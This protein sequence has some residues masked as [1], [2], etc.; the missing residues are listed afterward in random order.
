ME[1][2]I[3]GLIIA[4][5]QQLRAIFRTEIDLLTARLWVFSWQRAKIALIP[6]MVRERMVLKV[7]EVT[8]YPQLNDATRT[9]PSPPG[10]HFGRSP[11]FLNRWFCRSTSPPRRRNKIQLFGKGGKGHEKHNFSSF[12]T[13]GGRLCSN[14]GICPLLSRRLLP[15]S[16]QIFLVIP[17]ISE[18]IDGACDQPPLAVCGA[19][20]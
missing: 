1:A 17:E 9:A 7:S 5:V 13:N 3:Y 2:R 18:W 6:P 8:N 10:W 4:N 20:S 16:S 14:N 15:S 12:S 19:S 11:K